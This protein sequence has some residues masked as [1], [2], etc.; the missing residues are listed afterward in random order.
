MKYFNI[1]E[2]LY[3]IRKFYLFIYL[4]GVYIEE[5]F[6][7]IVGGI[8]VDVVGVDCSIGYIGIWGSVFLQCEIMRIRDFFSKY[9]F[10]G[11][12]ER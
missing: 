9:F 10:Y 4:I 11:F 3:K 7:Q 12:V 8:E 6:V 2:F 5:F 1:Y